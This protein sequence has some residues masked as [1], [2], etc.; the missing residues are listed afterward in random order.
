MKPENPEYIPEPGID[1]D[2]MKNM[3]RKIAQEASFSDDFGFSPEEDFTVVGIDQAFTSE[4]AVSAAVVMENGEVIEKVHG[5]ANLDI[6]YIP[7]LLAFR[8]GECIVEALEKLESDPDLLVL[9]G[10][11]RIHFRQAGIATHIGVIFDKPAIGVAK[12]LLCGQLEGS[13]EELEEGE[14]VEV[15]AD[16]KVENLETDGMGYAF[17]SRQYRNSYGINPLYVSPGHRVS[18]EAC[19]ELVEKFSNGY[20][21][22]EPTRVADR[23]VDRFKAEILE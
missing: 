18:N 19:V 10:S 20:K 22:P 9:D 12:N 13:V 3:Q 21:L 16:G 6:P 2:E 23:E 15:S 8:E 14:M 11:G 17:Q 1:S 4:K 7:G 5:V